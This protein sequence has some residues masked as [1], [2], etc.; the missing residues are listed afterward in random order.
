MKGGSFGGQFF[1]LSVSARLIR[2]LHFS[3]ISICTWN[4][5][6]KGGVMVNH[7][8]E[9]SSFSW[10]VEIKTICREIFSTFNWGKNYEIW[11][12]R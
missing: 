5:L 1:H 8:C 7:F 2:S 10:L 9:D 11:I 12:S 6:H 4:H 3:D